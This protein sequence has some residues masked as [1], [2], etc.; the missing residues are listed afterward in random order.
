MF[1]LQLLAD[2]ATYRAT[3]IGKRKWGRFWIHLSLWK[4]TLPWIVYIFIFIVLIF[5]FNLVHIYTIREL[6]YDG[7]EVSS[8]FWNTS[9]NYYIWTFWDSWIYLDGFLA[10]VLWGIL[11]HR[12]HTGKDSLADIHCFLG[13]SQDGWGAE[14]PESQLISIVLCLHIDKMN[15]KHVFTTIQSP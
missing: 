3:I 10:S 11:G 14:N 5:I 15:N 1:L 4:G 13:V 9:H 2:I 12:A 8:L 6:N 7:Q